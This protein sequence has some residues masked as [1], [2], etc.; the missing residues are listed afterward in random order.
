MDL[1]VHLL[2]IFPYSYSNSI[3]PLRGEGYL[4]FGVKSCLVKLIVSLGLV[5]V[6]V[7]GLLNK[8][9][10]IILEIEKNIVANRNEYND[11]WGF[12]DFKLSIPETVEELRKNYCKKV[13][14]EP[15]SGVT[16]VTS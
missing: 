1:M 8:G 3:Q 16:K 13:L 9:Q 15:N 5:K 7:E 14:R 10:V 4:V 2:P 12:K 6:R 11:I